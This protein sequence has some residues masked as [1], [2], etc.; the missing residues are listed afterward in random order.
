MEL[1]SLHSGVPHGKVLWEE[2]GQDKQSGSGQSS[3]VGPRSFVCGL[4]RG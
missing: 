2:G 1:L 3:I 4:G